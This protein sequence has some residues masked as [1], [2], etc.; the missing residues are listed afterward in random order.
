ML[1]LAGQVDGETSDGIKRRFG[2][3]DI[4]LLEDTTG[5]GHRSCVVGDQ[6]ALMAVV[7]LED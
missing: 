1:Y 6:E 3:G 5:K 2:P 4:V 7:Q